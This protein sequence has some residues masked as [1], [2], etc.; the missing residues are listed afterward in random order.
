MN[1]ADLYIEVEQMSAS[2]E[3]VSK[4]SKTQTLNVLKSK[5]DALFLQTSSD[6]I[7]GE[8][9][10][11]IDILNDCYNIDMYKFQLKGLTDIMQKDI[12]IMQE[13]IALEIV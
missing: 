3:I 4:V 6:L 2:N 8:I 9:A 1:N 11:N 5:L 12:K 13:M 7:K 10:T